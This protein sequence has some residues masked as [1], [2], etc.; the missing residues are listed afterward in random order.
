MEKLMTLGAFYFSMFEQELR[1]NNIPLEV[2]YLPV[3]ES[4][5]N[6][7]A[8]SRA[9]AVGLWQFIYTTGRVYGLDVNS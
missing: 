8:K 6:P 1:N 4:A 7:R 5:L 3:V 9:G 2:K